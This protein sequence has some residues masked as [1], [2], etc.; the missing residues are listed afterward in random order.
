VQVGPTPIALPARCRPARC[1]W[2]AAL[3]SGTQIAEELYESRRKVFLAVRPDRAAVPRNGREPVV[4]K[5]R[6]LWP[7]CPLPGPPRARGR[8]AGHLQGLAH[9]RIRFAPDLLRDA[10]PREVLISVRRAS[11]RPAC[12]PPN[13]GRK[14]R[15]PGSRVRA[16][17]TSCRMRSAS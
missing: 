11:R 5:T 3:S 9:G 10:G 7:C 1:G 2:W 15:W 16:S 8:S 12:Y 14:C 17:K 13:A 6:P 4:G